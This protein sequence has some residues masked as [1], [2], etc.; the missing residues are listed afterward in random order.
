MDIVREITLPTKTIL[1]IDDEVSVREVVEL[2]LKDLALWNVVT[3]DCPLKG[4]HRAAVI[5][6]D[7]IVLDWS[8]SGMDSCMFLTKL[9]N[10]LETQAI[11][12][13]LLSA[14]A[15]WLDSQI[16]RQYQIAGVILKPFDPVALPGQVA[17]LLGWSFT[18]PL[19]DFDVSS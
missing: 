9:R 11:P 17:K 5:H 6:P 19:S 13:V 2:S 7:A 4:L 3:A 8:I 12:V 16:L 14:K 15:R 10:N 18:L 1:L